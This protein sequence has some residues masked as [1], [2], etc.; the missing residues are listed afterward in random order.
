MHDK[1]RRTVPTGGDTDEGKEV[2]QPT[3][4][5]KKLA[6]VFGVSATKVAQRSHEKMKR[7]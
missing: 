5:G 6:G 7:S 4:F 2:V 1:E 3:E